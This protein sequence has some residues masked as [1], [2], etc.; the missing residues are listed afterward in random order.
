MLIT[1]GD[2]NSSVGGIQVQA[3]NT[4]LEPGDSGES[5]DS[6]S[7]DRIFEILS[8][9]R[10]RRVIRYLKEHAGETEIR[11]RDLAEQ[12]AAWE[13][14]TT[15]SEVTYKQRK[16]VYTSL[17]QSHLPKMYEYGFVNYDKNR[18]TVSLT[19]ESANLDVYLEVIPEGDLTWGDFS[20]G[21]SAVGL[22]FVTAS[23]FGAIPFVSG[24]LVAFMIAIAFLF[25]STAHAIYT[26]QNRL[27]E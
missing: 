24:W 18:G 15:L 14:E 10:R 9:A 2:D 1:A 4:R 20:V 12:L 5:V 6:M 16:R 7:K 19:P 25:I 22:A 26:R 3:I 27:L 23:W 11:R 17:Y 8:S 13:N 21:L